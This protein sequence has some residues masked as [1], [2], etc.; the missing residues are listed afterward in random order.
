MKKLL[1]AVSVTVVAAYALS[2]PVSAQRGSAERQARPTPRPA[3]QPPGTPA[4]PAPPATAPQLDAAA[5]CL[6]GRDGA[7]ADIILATA[8]YSA[9]E[10]TEAVRVLRELQTCAGGTRMSSSAHLI[11]GALA[12]AVLES[13]F[14]TPQAAATPPIAVRPLLRVELATTRT[15]A[16]GLA[17][18][19]A[20]A[21]CVAA[22]HQAPVRGL[23]AAEPGTP[24]AT[25]AFSALSPA[26]SACATGNLQLNID[27]RTL[28]GVLAEDLYR[29]S[30]AQRDGAASPYARP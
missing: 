1:L 9:E 26:F 21:E 20:L 30:A 23:I 22:G 16:A 6:I 7:A 4:P 18:A 13:R 19:Y 12:E 2:A 28:R 27:G 11:R 10:R 24:A 15:D 14:A 3:S 25:A 8:P 5:R 17:P 29:W